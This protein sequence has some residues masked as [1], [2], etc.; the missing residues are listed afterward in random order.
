MPADRPSRRPGPAP[1]GPAYRGDGEWARTPS[2]VGNPRGA[3]GATRAGR[4]Y[5]EGGAELRGRGAG[6]N[7][8]V[9]HALTRAERF[10]PEGAQGPGWR[11]GGWSVEAEE[12]DDEFDARR[13]M[14]GINALISISNGDSVSYDRHSQTEGIRALISIANEVALATTSR[15]LIVTPTGEIRKQ[16]RLSVISKLRK[17]EM[18]WNSL[19]LILNTGLMAGTGFLFWIVATRL[20]TRDDVGVGSTLINASSLIAQLALLGLG[21]GMS[22]FL[23][24]ARNRDALISSGL[25]LV[26]MAGA[27]GAIVYILL[28]SLV[29]PQLEFVSK[30]PLLI[31]GFAGATGALAVNTLTDNVFIALRKAKYTVFVDGVVGGFGKIALAFVLVAVGAYGFFLASSI[32]LTLAAATSLVI[33]F[34]VMRVRVDLR[35]PVKALKPL[36][37]FSGANYIGTVINLVVGLISSVILLRRL[38]AD[39]VAI[40]SVVLQMTQIMYTAGIALE[41]TFLTEGSQPGADIPKLR[42]RALRLLLLFFVAGATI[43]IGL[44]R[45]LLLAFGNSSYSQQGYKVLVI[46]VLGA[47]PLAIN[48][49]FQTI[50]RLAGKLRSI[51]VVNASGAI[52]SCA[53]VWVGSSF[54]LTGVAL[55]SLSCSTIAMCIAGIAARERRA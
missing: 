53:G 52:L 34:M 25:A 43:M 18:T 1:D 48:L 45:W 28:A 15:E 49:W 30:S 2:E 21:V 24:S 5:P 13:Q 26:A 10:P 6:G 36:I 55:G 39:S 44:G 3:P 51:V 22:R 9:R 4:V 11:P 23:P 7:R 14:A 33:I 19:F 32:A 40:Y 12:S 27:F 35:D 29:A 46:L 50:L 47:G 41:Q 42:R 37:R 16:S 31:L 8:S 20:F 38:G 54:G 17:D